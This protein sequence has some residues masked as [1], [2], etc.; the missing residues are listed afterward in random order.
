MRRL[1]MTSAVVAATLMAA[2]PALTP[3][4]ALACATNTSGNVTLGGVSGAPCLNV[5]DG[6]VGTVT[7]ANGVTTSIASLMAVSYQ[8]G[9]GTV[10][11]PGYAVIGQSSNFT[12]SSILEILVQ[13]PLTI[14]GTLNSNNPRTGIL[15]ENISN[16]SN[17]QNVST[18]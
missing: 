3:A 10:L 9:G 17:M 1:C 15:L 18:V 16:F 14:G 11:A 6:T 7:V 12:N 8:V 4:P 5:Q 2:V 13:S